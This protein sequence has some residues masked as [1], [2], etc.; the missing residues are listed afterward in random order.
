MGCRKQGWHPTADCEDSEVVAA[1]QFRKLKSDLFNTSGCVPAAQNEIMTRNTSVSRF[2]RLPPE[3]RLR[4]Y[5]L[6]LGGQQVWIGSIP[7]QTSYINLLGDWELL[8]D[9][10]PY[11][12][13]PRLPESHRKHFSQHDR[14]HCGGGFFHRNIDGSGRGGELDLRLLRVCRQVFTETALLP[15]AFNKFT[16]QRDDVR[17]AFEKI[18][19]PGKK[20]VQKR[21][22]GEYEIMEWDEFQSRLL[23]ISEYSRTPLR[24]NS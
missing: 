5:K 6:V 17:R 7:P 12:S 10:T 11:S 14:E 9:D 1:R 16:F 24:H 18:A 21:A 2:L 19:R 8:I 22:V 13:P 4:I 23:G 3:I 20:L 15:Y